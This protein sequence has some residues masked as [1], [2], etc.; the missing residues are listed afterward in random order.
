MTTRRWI[1]A[2]ALLVLVAWTL[3]VQSPLP[4]MHT[5]NWEYALSLQ[6]LGRQGKDDRALR[7]EFID[8][9]DEALTDDAVLVHYAPPD[10]LL[11]SPT[12][13]R[14]F[15]HVSV[16]IFPRRPTWLEAPLVEL[17]VVRAE[18]IGRC[19]VLESAKRPYEGGRE[20]FDSIAEWGEFRLLR[21]A[22]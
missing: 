15:A 22:R 10:F 16:R 21:L 6:T 7:R 1:T 11:E 4:I 18:D 9:I 13:L 20:R 3:T 14:F 5:L 19:L 8:A 2:A 17:P 12:A